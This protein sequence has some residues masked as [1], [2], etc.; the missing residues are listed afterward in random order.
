M[1]SI[2]HDEIE[3]RIVEVPFTTSFSTL[4][5][6]DFRNVIRNPMLIKMRIVQTIFIGVYSGGLF[7]KFTG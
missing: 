7:C 2:S 4:V 6:R 1:K 3:K 5:S